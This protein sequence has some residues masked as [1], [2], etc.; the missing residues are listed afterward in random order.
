MI[1]NYIMFPVLDALWPW[2][3][4]TI[5]VAPFILVIVALQAI[6]INLRTPKDMIDNKEFG[7]VL[8][9]IIEE[10]GSE[11][12]ENIDENKVYLII[13]TLNQLDA[14]VIRNKLLLKVLPLKA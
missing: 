7:T 8:L 12:I 1:L 2:I 11:R 9:R 13:N 3:F 10:I 6:N 4:L 5:F 14:D